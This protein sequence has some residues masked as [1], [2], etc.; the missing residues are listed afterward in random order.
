MRLP[1]LLT[2]PPARHLLAFGLVFA[3]TLHAAW[4]TID[5]YFLSDDFAYIGR[6]YHLAWADWPALFVRDW[7]GGLWGQGLPELRPFAA[8]T[9]LVDAR[10]WG[11]NPLGYHITNLLLDTGCAWLVMLIVWR[12][13]SAALWAG[14]AAGIL[15]A[16]QPAHAEPVAWITGRVDLLGTLAYLVG[17]FAAGRYLRAGGGGRWL[18]A[19]WLA[20]G[21]GCF[22]KE[23]CLTMPV[24]LLLWM[25]FYRPLLAPRATRPAALL[26]AGFVAVAVV[27]VLCRRIAFGPGSGG[28]AALNLLSP[29]FAERQ[30]DYLRWA[31]PLFY[32]FGRDYRPALVAIAPAL[33]VGSLGVSIAIL[34][35]WHWKG[36]A[37]TRW[38][39]VAFFG[40][41]WYAVATLPMAAASYFSPRHLYLATAGLCIGAGLLAATFA[42]RR[43]LACGLIALAALYSAGRFHHAVAPWRHSAKLSERVAQ[44]VARSASELGPGEVLLLDVPDVHEGVWL[45]SWA[46]PFALQPPFLTQAAPPTLTR[47][48]VY[49]SPP[50]WSGQPL[51]ASLPSA[52][53]AILISL[54]EKGTVTARHLAGARVAGPAR[55]LAQAAVVDPH[56]AWRDFIGTLLAR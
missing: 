2:T 46:A 1:V 50:G 38:R 49:Y 15:F 25:I 24:A 33:I 26:F 19:A 45:W 42:S 16:W 37:S 20:Y 23:F 31:V 48:A 9:F 14:C 17:F 32:D 7:S 34:A 40:L 4:G 39:A 8:L 22:S 29:A 43:W 53:G 27:F 10:L 52:S 21:V 5:R 44:Q 36:P 30:F 56:L 35:L 54:D 12:L 28:V 18:A 11:V 3:A 6:F 13:H 41:V 51:L 55:V 47:P